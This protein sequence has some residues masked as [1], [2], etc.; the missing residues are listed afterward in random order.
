MPHVHL[1]EP[2]RNV[3]N[4]VAEVGRWLGEPYVHH[5]SQVDQSHLLLRASQLKVSYLCMGDFGT[6]TTDVVSKQAVG[7]FSNYLADRYQC[8]YHDGCSSGFLNVFSGVPQGLV[9]SPIVFSIYVNALGRNVRNA[10]CHCYADDTVLCCFGSTL[11][12]AFDHFA[13]CI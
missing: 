7:W 4:W 12:Q 1:E 10:K 3:C 13:Y 9:L 5:V 6:L 2:R 8:V 11:N